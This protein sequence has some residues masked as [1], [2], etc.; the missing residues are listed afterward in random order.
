[1]T[2]QLLVVYLSSTAITT[3]IN[4]LTIRSIWG[5]CGPHALCGELHL[6]AKIQLSLSPCIRWLPSDFGSD[7]RGG[8]GGLEEVSSSLLKVS[9]TVHGA[10]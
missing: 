3:S 5:I 4:K 9:W 2:C 7:D 6:I 10:S 1:M 8:G